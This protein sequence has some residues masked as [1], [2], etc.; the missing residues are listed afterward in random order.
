MQISR[1]RF[2]LFAMVLSLFC[3]TVGAVAEAA[4]QNHMVNARGNLNSALNE[5]YAATAD[6]GGHRANAINDTRNAISEV[7]L[8]IKYSNGQY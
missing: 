3:V 7:D 4:Y 5:L 6:K 2:A 8:G 1:L